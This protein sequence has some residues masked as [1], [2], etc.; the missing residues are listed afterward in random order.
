MVTPCSQNWRALC[1]P[2]TVREHGFFVVTA[3]QID[4]NFVVGKTMVLRVCN[5]RVPSSTSHKNVGKPTNFF[6]L[7]LIDGSFLPVRNSSSLFQALSNLRQTKNSHFLHKDL[8]FTSRFRG[9]FMKA[10]NFTSLSSLIHLN[11]CF[12]RRCFL[13]P[14][15]VFE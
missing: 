11:L 12:Y 8:F 3:S 13:H 6:W 7:M 15:Y 10:P 5:A 4:A 14:L 9:V 1:F 2:N